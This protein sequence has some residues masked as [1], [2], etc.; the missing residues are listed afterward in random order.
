MAKYREILRLHAQDEYCGQSE[1][2]ERS[3]EPPFA[4]ERASKCGE[5]SH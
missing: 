4:E 2:L 3:F 5:G 1:P